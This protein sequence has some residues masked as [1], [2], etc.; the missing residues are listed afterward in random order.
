[1]ADLVAAPLELAQKTGVTIPVIEAPPEPIAMEEETTTQ[2]E[3]SRQADQ[4]E[5]QRQFLR[6]QI[7]RYENARKQLNPELDSEMTQAYDRKISEAKTAITGL[8]PLNTRIEQLQQ[9]VDGQRK[10]VAQ[11]NDAIT[12]WTNLRD[13]WAEK[14][15]AKELELQSM[16][17]EQSRLTAAGAT[18]LQQ[19]QQ[20]QQQL[21]QPQLDAVQLLR[22]MIQAQAGGP[23]ELQSL[24]HNATIQ[25]GGASVFMMPTPVVPVSLGRVPADTQPQS[26]TPITIHHSD[27]QSTGMRGSPPFD[28]SLFGSASVTRADPYT[29]PTPQRQHAAAH[30][31][32]RRARSLSPRASPPPPTTGGGRTVGQRF[33]QDLRHHARVKKTHFE[34]PRRNDELEEA[35]QQEDLLASHAT[36]MAE[37][38]EMRGVTEAQDD[39]QL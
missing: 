7:Y 26:S 38:A 22:S 11:A 14:A 13:A 6:A 4:H 3:T 24:I 34:K 32:E 10:R 12:N 1:L 30:S 21:Q 37:Q 20:L 15:N 18:Q 35:Q 17:A 8:K 19:Q 39:S 36:L 27:L 28:P 2:P 9:I 5:E 31:P 29:I 33:A 23:A 25:L 16:K